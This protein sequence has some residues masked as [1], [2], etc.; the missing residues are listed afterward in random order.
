MIRPLTALLTSLLIVTSTASA[1]G[2]AKRGERIL[3]PRA[4][5]SPRVDGKFGK[6][7]WSEAVT[8]ALAD[9]GQASL[10]HDA[11][12]LYIAMV[13]KKPGTTS[14]CVRWQ[15]PIWVLHASS[16]LGTVV[17][18]RKGGKWTTPK[19]FQFTNRD[20]TDSQQGIRDRKL[21]L[22]ARHWFAN[23]YPEIA[24]LEREYQIELK[25]KSELQLVLAYMSFVGEDDLDLDAWPSK[26][27][28]G[29]VELDLVRGYA[30]GRDF[31]FEPA[32]W[33]VA[34]MQ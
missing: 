10:I 32:T 18:H 30:T 21:I 15:K 28:D 7:E 4:T 3:V 26:V 16:G 20:T 17:F 5:K 33:G 31:K 22:G 25:G 8:V 29:C 1:A 12:Y 34:V 13:G 2:P 14:V 27:V 23:T 24:G 6:T 9:G 11:K 19:N